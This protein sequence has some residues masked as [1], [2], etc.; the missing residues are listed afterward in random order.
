MPFPKCLS[1]KDCQTE[2][3]EVRATRSG[4]M[5]PRSSTSRTASRPFSPPSG[6]LMEGHAVWWKVSVQG[7]E[8]GPVRA[9]WCE[10]LR[11]CC[12]V[13]GIASSTSA[14]RHGTQTSVGRLD[15]AC[16]NDAVQ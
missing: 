2:V 10:C 13:Q 11:M 6:L 9:R 3:E 4:R 16:S 8:E 14:R 15:L 1:P 12:P 7:S 5:C